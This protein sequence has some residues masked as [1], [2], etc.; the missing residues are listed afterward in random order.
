M[1]AVFGKEGHERRL[2]K[3]CAGLVVLGLEL[4]FLR[5]SAF[6]NSFSS[7]RVV[8]TF[9]LSMSSVSQGFSF[10]CVDGIVVVLWFEKGI[11]L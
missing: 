8:S 4:F 2:F 11:K 9:H 3:E 7:F 10:L 1:F 6:V 5:K